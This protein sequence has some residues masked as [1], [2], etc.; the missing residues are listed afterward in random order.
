MSM[1]HEGTISTTAASKV[2]SKQKKSCSS[3]RMLVHLTKYQKEIQFVMTQNQ[4]AL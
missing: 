1:N 3:E 2:S 4:T